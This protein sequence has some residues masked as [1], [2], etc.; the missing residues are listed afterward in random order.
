MGEGLILS[1]LSLSSLQ[2]SSFGPCCTHPRH[3][4]DTPANREH[5]LARAGSRDPA[6][7][8]DSSVSMDGQPPEA[9]ACPGC[10]ILATPTAIYQHKVTRIFLEDGNFHRLNRF[11]FSNR[12]GNIKELSDQFAGTSLVVQGL[13]LSDP[14]AGGLGAILSQ[15]TGS[16][17][18]Q[19]KDPTRRK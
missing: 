10:V 16:H 2:S 13:R 1:A 19:Q 9:V 18:P 4:A 6:A 3:H 8:L 12:G 17:M 14:N 5:R 7:C 11:K 15:G